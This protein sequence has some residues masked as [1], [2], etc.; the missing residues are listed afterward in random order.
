[1]TYLVIYEVWSRVQDV[2]DAGVAESASVHAV[3]DFFEYDQLLAQDA[4]L[5]PATRVTLIS[6]CICI[7]V[8]SN[9]T[10]F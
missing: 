6:S 2:V 4:G 7:H 8:T 9:S 1:M 3:V 10:R 5:L